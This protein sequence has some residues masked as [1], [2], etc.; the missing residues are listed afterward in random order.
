MK[1]AAAA[2]ALLISAAALAADRLDP[3]RWTLAVDAPA[4]PGATVNL[5]CRAVTKL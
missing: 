4:P 1:W 2:L 3:V 5:V